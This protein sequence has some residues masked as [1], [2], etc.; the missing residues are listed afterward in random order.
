MFHR[1]AAFL[2]TTPSLLR[3]RV[4]RLRENPDAGMTMAEYLL[5]LAIVV[6]IGLVLT[7]ILVPKF[8]AKAN[9]INLN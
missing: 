7:A 4:Q 2:S 3:E 6:A 8:T 5:M 9:G 1:V